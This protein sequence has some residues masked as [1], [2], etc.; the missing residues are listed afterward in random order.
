M[1][2]TYDRVFSPLAQ[3]LEAPISD[4]S[5]MASIL[6]ELWSQHDERFLNHEELRI[7]KEGR[8]NIEWLILS[9]REKTAEVDKAHID[10]NNAACAAERAAG[11]HRR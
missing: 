9:L 7:D 5:R 10:A 2:A 8:K 1:T 11:E 4:C 3:A 6:N